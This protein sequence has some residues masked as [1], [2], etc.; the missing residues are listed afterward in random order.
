MPTSVPNAAVQMCGSSSAS[1]YAPATF[2]W[3]DTCGSEQG[4]T[5]PFP[6]FKRDI[7]SGTDMQLLDMSRAKQVRRQGQLWERVC[8]DPTH[9]SH[10]AHPPP[11]G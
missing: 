3:S 4:Q 11:P 2:T 9:S 5:T 6:Q 8:L 10:N 7:A 1:C